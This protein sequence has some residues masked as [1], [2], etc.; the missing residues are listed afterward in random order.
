VFKNIVSMD[1]PVLG[2][3]KEYPIKK[4]DLF[5]SFI[6]YLETETIQDNYSFFKLYD[7][8]IHEPENMANYNIDL[9][10]DHYGNVQYYLLFYHFTRAIEVSFV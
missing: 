5:S 9:E 1:P 4:N 10:F 8:F 2:N 7:D 3:F 6:H